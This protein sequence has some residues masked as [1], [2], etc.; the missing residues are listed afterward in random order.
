M[1]VGGGPLR[2]LKSI[3]GDKR[4]AHLPIASAM[5]T[6]DLERE[7]LAQLRE[8]LAGPLGG[9]FSTALRLMRAAPGRVT[10][11]LIGTR[12]WVTHGKRLVF[13]PCSDCERP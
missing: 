8:A 12:N 6:L 3:D 13:A 9:P 5:R 4:L 7:G 2:K 1:T 10:V 11:L